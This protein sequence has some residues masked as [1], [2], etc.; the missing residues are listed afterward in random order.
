MNFKIK[1]LELENVVVFKTRVKIDFSR[2]SLNHIEAVYL[3]DVNQSNGAG[4]SVIIDAISLALFGKGVRFQYLQDYILE[5]NASGGIYIGLELE[6][7]GSGDLLK[8]ERWKR[9]GSDTTKAK[10]WWKGE[11]ISKDATNQKIDEMLQ[12]YTGV[13]HSNFLSTIFSVMLPGFLTLRA[14]QRFEVLENALAIR[15]MDNVIKKINAVLRTTEESMAAVMETLLDKSNLLGQETAKRD[16]YLSNAADLQESIL[17]QKQEYAKYSDREQEI[18]LK[19]TSYWTLLEESRVRLKKKEQSRVEVKA[20]LDSLNETL[21]KVTSRLTT[22]SKAL[23]QR[24]NS[25][26]ECIVCKSIISKD[27]ERSIREHYEE[28]ISLLKEEQSNLNAEFK[29]LSK[30]IVKL[31]GVEAKITEAITNLDSDLRFIQS[32]MLASEKIISTTSKSLEETKKTYEGSKLALLEKETKELSESRLA[33]TKDVK[34]ITAWKAAMSKNG[35]RLS[36]IK[37]EVGTLSAIASKYASAVY[38]TP[39]AVKF[40]IS[41]EKDTPSLDFTVNGRNAMAFSSGERRLLEI[42]V[43]LSLL[44]LLKSAGLNLDFIILDECTDS[45]AVTSKTNVLNLIDSLSSTNQIIVISHDKVM[46]QKPGNVILITKDQTTKLS[47]VTQTI[48]T[49]Q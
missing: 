26:L 18:L 28:E 39:T 17:N 34:M 25:A 32:S 9:P 14:S 13:S 35:L 40:F 3:E 45:L 46:Q 6:E 30:E 10:L 36:Y 4:K 7:A 24:D 16:L 33:L 43:T 8:I 31:S 21:S 38:N 19:R 27:S 42:A 12:T 11:C 5:S 44:T 48:R 23:K 15:R 2:T 37:E 41:E 29:S 47:T 1:S 49:I 20:K 22:V